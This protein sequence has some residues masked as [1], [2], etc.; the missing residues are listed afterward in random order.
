MRNKKT[1]L[2]TLER[3][4]QNHIRILTAERI[5]KKR[6]AEL[7]R[8]K[9]GLAPEDLAAHYYAELEQYRKALHSGGGE[10]LRAAYL[11]GKFD[12]MFGRPQQNIWKKRVAAGKV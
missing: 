4:L 8:T 6:A 1:V 9:Y 7:K 11:I 10:A 5:P 12:G 3:L 2:R